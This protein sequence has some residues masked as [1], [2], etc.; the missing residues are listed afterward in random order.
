[1]EYYYIVANYLP[2][3]GLA[4]SEMR[5]DIHDLDS[6]TPADDHVFTVDQKKQKIFYK[7]IICTKHNFSAWIINILLNRG[8][9]LFPWSYW[10][11]TAKIYC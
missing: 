11:L 9:A 7:K 8:K 4:A 10:H 6:N 2:Y 5:S 3:V 1:M